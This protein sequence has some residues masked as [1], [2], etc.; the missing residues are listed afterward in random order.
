[1]IA[2]LVGVAMGFA[3]QVPIDQPP[4]LRT[5]LPNG[6]HV[7]VERVPGAKEVAIGLFVSSNGSQESV[8]THGWRHLLEHFLARGVEGATDLKL[9]TA[10]GY[11]RARTL[12]DA[13]AFEVS[14]P[15]DRLDLGIAALKEVL[16][17]PNPT[18]EQIAREVQVIEEEGALRDGAARVSETA[19]RVAYGPRGLDPFGELATMASAT[20]KA[21]A[22]LRTRMFTG[23][24]VAVVV[25]GDVDL[26]K[27]TAA[28]RKLV[29]PLPSAVRSASPPPAE[30][31]SGR[32]G[33]DES[34]HHRALPVGDIRSYRTVAALAAALALA[35][36][37]K[38]PSVIYTPSASTGLIVLGSLES[39]DSF[40]K[41]LNQSDPAAL[42]ERG[43]T[44]ARRWVRQ[45]L[46][47]PGEIVA[48][49][50]LLLVQA[51]DLRPEMIVEQIDALPFAE[52][53]S[54]VAGFRGPKAI[55]VEGN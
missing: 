48:F 47:E 9:E 33:I 52:F 21:L 53:A 2:L 55:E 32:T 1:M 35:A 7:L 26:D 6:A 3:P 20:P 49:R 36:D 22:T 41:R 4:R 40:R 50:G 8:A 46:R 43:R 15:A 25:A 14:L 23:P 24:G 16:G 34:G 10:G 17:A 30:P 44:L 29:E 19:W 38:R 37:L 28:V 12:R 31:T 11:L 39:G 51:P 13:M 54:A 27:T 5:K 18:A 45:R 42:F